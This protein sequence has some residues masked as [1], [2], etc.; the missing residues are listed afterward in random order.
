M[1]LPRYHA[2][3]A[4]LRLRFL[5]PQDDLGVDGYGTMS[6]WPETVGETSGAASVIMRGGRP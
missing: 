3:I 2:T 6:G 5:L 4:R 1:M